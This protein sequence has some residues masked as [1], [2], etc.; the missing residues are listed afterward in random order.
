MGRYGVGFEAPP[1]MRGTIFNDVRLNRALVDEARWLTRMINPLGDAL[2]GPV[3]GLSAGLLGDV[4]Q[5]RTFVEQFSSR[6][7][8]TALRTG[9]E[10]SSLASAIASGVTSSSAVRTETL[11]WGSEREWSS[12]LFALGRSWDR[13]LTLFESALPGYELE[14]PVEV[15]VRAWNDIVA[16]AENAS[17]VR[18]PDRV[19]ATGRGALGVLAAGTLVLEDAD[20]E[21][22]AFD[23]D[24]EEEGLLSRDGLS[25]AL[26]RE[27]RNLHPRLP[28]RLDSAWTQVGTSD[29]SSPS[30]AAHA[31]MELIDWSLRIAAPDA[32]VLA[33]HADQRRPREEVVDGRPTR[34]LRA[35]YVL[36]DRREDQRAAR[37]LIRGLDDIVAQVQKYKH[38]IDVDDGLAVARLIP[39]V[40]GILIYLFV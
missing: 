3:L 32:A 9:F 19:L 13:H 24:D 23:L 5:P 12:A 28:A 4:R 10:T 21:G 40:E 11:L 27:L 38:D 26:R 39:A 14:R 8:L 2:R 17:S 25:T 7:Y 29:P 16:R 34:N 35:R 18:A 37:L 22:E 31:L 36:Q 15:T 20:E 30:L 6:S 33:W 1:S